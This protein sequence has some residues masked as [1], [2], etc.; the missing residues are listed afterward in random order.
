MR[1]KLYS[2]CWRTYGTERS[3]WSARNGPTSSAKAGTGLRASI[4][5]H[6]E[7]FFSRVLWGGD[8]AAGDSYVD[9]DW[10][11]PDPVAVVRLA[12]RNLAELEGGNPLLSFANRFIHRLRHRM[13]RNTVVGSRRN[14]HGAL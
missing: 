5:V 8:D 12:A 14:I 1:G 7:R 6:D 10:S 2:G 9:G 3:K 11:S 4:A 13:N